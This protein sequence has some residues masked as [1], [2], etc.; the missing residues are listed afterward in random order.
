[1]D[2]IFNFPFYLLDDIDFLS[3]VQ[4]Q[5]EFNEDD[6]DLLNKLNNMYYKP[7][8]IDVN[9]HTEN[10]DPDSFLQGSLGI[11]IPECKYYFL[12]TPECSFS[13]SQETVFSLIHLN[14]CSIPK[15][16]DTFIDE[17]I[18]PLKLQ[19]DVI[20]FC[21]T[22][23]TNDLE[24]LY[25]IPTYSRFCNNHSRNSGGVALYIL[26]KY[27]CHKRSDLS[28]QENCIESLFVEVGSDVIVDVIYRRSITSSRDFLERSDGLLERLES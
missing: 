10:V 26:D 25:D 5:G 12:D 14:I 16:L 27:E 22:R 3:Y 9:T 13:H 23:L 4:D 2:E 11:S 28:Y 20:G 7:I 8:N 24:H 18:S 15:H 1:M 17:C 21:E 6:V 19:F